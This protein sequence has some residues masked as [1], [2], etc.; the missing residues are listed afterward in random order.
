MSASQ[1]RSYADLIWQLLDLKQGMTV[2]DLACGH[3][4]IANRLA[5]RGC[6]VAGLDSSAVFLG[7]ARADADALDVSVG[8][9]AGDMWE[10]PWTGRFDRI[11]N[12]FTA[13]GYFDDPVN[14]RVLGEAA[15]ALRP[16][17]RLAL[18]LN[19]VV[20]WLPNLEPARVAVRDD[21]DMFVDRHRLDPLT[22]RL[23]VERIFIRDD[24]VRRVQYFVRVFTFPELQD[25]LLAAGFT[26]ATGYGEDGQAL[27]AAPRG[28]RSW[29]TTTTASW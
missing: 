9:V 6:Q 22:G 10:L 24:R 26:G 14:R 17:G 25:G 4:R 13:F 11:V 27:G 1:P 28:S 18:D 29:R 23:V 19:N 5:A 2:L 16:G 12:W 3:G 8:Y 7:R 15:Q 20:G 21:G